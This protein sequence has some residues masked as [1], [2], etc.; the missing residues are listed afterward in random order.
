MLRLAASARR[1]TLAVLGAT[2]VV[3]AAAAARPALLVD[4]VTFSYKVSSSRKD[5]KG[6]PPFTYLSTIRMADGNIRM[7]YTDGVNP[8][9]GKDGY[10]VIRG[11]DERIALVNAKD[12]QVMVMDAATLGSGMGAMLN[13]PMLKLAF[14]DQSFSY[15]DL[16]PGETILGNRT[17]KFRLTQ[18]YTIEMRVMGMRRSATEESVTDQ[19]IA[20]EVKGVDARAMQKWAKAFGSGIKVTNAEL[21]AQMDRFMKETKGGLA[22]KSVVVATHN[23]GKKTETDTTTMEI[24]DLKNASMDASIFTWPESYAVVDMGQ[25]FAGIGDSIRAANARAGESA[26]ATPAVQ[27]DTAKGPSIKDEIKKEGVKAGI[28]GILGRKKP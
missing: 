12:K 27:T 28:R 15:E 25:V 16:G 9:L 21:A 26:T 1:R 13:S 2:L 7:D 17:R 4:G 8:M 11:N 19:W 20:S 18:K 24:V 5:Q 3:G 22:L 6:A 10:M 14:K 23:D